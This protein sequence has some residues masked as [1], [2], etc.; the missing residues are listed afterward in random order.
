MTRINLGVHPSELCDQMLAA[1]YR[2]LPRTVSIIN[3][4]LSSL[5]HLGR[6]PPLPTLGIGHV[7]YFLPYGKSL[8]DRFK[9]I[10]DEMLSRNFNI[11][12]REI[13]PA[14]DG[15]IPNEHIGGFLRD[16]RN[17]IIDNL[18][19]MK[20]QPRWSKG[21]PIWLLDKL[22]PINYDFKYHLTMK[23]EE[24]WDNYHRIMP[25]NLQFELRQKITII[26]DILL[27]V[28]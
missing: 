27:N 8:R 5:G 28:K 10:V 6:C 1:E 11:K 22:D 13:N 18:F 17:R 16:I 25:S 23:A 14:T 12:F 21:G 24:I 3:K 4:R 20:D 15:E 2:E 9:T 7:S 26:K 19:K